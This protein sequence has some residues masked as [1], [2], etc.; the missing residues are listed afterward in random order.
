MIPART[1]L[2][3]L[4][5]VAAVALAAERPAAWGFEAHRLI[6]DRAIDLLPADDPAR[7]S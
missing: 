5:V 2:F 3:P 1:L 6:A 7:S 4:A